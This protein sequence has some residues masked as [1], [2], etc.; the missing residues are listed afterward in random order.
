MK[1][2]EI[3]KGIL[4]TSN[5]SVHAIV[6]HREFTGLDGDALREAVAKRYIDVKETNNA[7]EVCYFYKGNLII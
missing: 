2:L 7:S 6:Y 1:E 4:Q 3:N 5:P